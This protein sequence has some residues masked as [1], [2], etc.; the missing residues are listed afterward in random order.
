VQGS[1]FGRRAGKRAAVPVE[2]VLLADGPVDR[3]GDA[4]ISRLLL[5]FT[6]VFCGLAC[7][8]IDPRR[9]APA[10]DTAQLPHPAAPS[11]P[12]VPRDASAQL[13][14]AP[15]GSTAVPVLSPLS[16]GKRLRLVGVGDADPLEIV[17]PPK[18]RL[19]MEKSEEQLPSAHL[20][21][22]DLEIVVED[23]ESG[24][25]TLTEKKSSIGRGDPAATFIHDEQMT[26]G[27]LLVYRSNTPGIGPQ[28]N[29][30][31][32][33]P[34]LKAVCAAYLLDKLLDAERTASICLSLKAIP[35]GGE[36]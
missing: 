24:F 30:V 16:N 31:V 3:F 10:R 29:A 4:L 19:K 14:A 25:A 34:G 27:Y 23:P 9:A 15:S 18:F 36:N 22:P 5:A 7:T 20:K 1:T 35:G 8:K 17:V 32:S 21:G 13:A 6:V 33:R 11:R 26:D 28:Y 12:D 2:S